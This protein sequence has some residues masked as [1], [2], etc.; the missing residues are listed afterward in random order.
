MIRNEIN[1][2]LLKRKP[3]HLFNGDAVKLFR[4]TQNGNLVCGEIM[5]GVD[6]GKWTTVDLTKA[7]RMC[8]WDDDKYDVCYNCIECREHY[9]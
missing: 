7:V 6:K 1:P 5:D 9:R 4:S 2:E 8:F 3:T